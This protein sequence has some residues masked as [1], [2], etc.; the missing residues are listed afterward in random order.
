MGQ[1]KKRKSIKISVNQLKKKVEFR[2][3]N[4]Q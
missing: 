4:G 2:D 3:S 1:I